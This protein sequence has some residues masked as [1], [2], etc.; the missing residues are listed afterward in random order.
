M[1]IVVCIKQVVGS[2]RVGIDPKT[3]TLLRERVDAIINPFDEYAIEAALRVREQTGGWV[4]VM[5]MGPPRA[6]AALRFALAMGADEGHLIT[7]RVFAGSDT[8]ATAHVLSRAILT[9]R[10]SRP[11]H[12][13]KAG[14]R[15]RYRP[16]RS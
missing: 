12:L 6:E 10:H 8:W 1:N 4:Q 5:T 13:R 16:G 15:R 2:S 7:D 14:H 3:G 11:H 9:P